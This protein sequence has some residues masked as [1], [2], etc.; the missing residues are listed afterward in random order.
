MGDGDE[1]TSKKTD[2]NLSDAIDPSSPYYLHPSDFPKKLHVN[3]VLTDGNYMDWAQEMSNFL[4][5][6]N[7]IDFVDGTI[8]KPKIGSTKY[9][10]WM[11]CDAMIK[12]WL[13]TAVEKIIRDS[14]KKS[15]PPV[16]MAAAFPPTT[17]VSELC[18]TSL[19]RSA[20]FRDA[21]AMA[22]HTQILATKLIP[23]L[24]TAYHMVA[25]DERHRKISN[26]NR[27]TSE[28]ATF[29][30]F[31]KREG[32]TRFFKEKSTNKKWP[33]KKGDK[34]KPMAACVDT[35]ASPILGISDE[36]YKLFVNFFSG[37]GSKNDVETKLEANLAGV[38]YEEL[39]WSGDVSFMENVFPFKN[40][41]EGNCYNDDG[42][43]KIQNETPHDI[44]D[45][46]KIL[47]EEESVQAQQE[48]G[49]DFGTINQQGGDDGVE[50]TFGSNLDLG[51]EGHDEPANIQN[52]PQRRSK[53]TKEGVD[54]H[55]TFAPVAKLVTVRTLLVIATK[56]N[57]IIH[58]LDVNN[59]FLH[60]DLDEEVYMKIP[61]GFSRDGET[62][63]GGVYVAILIY[64]DDVIII[65]NNTKKIQQTKKELDEE[66]SIKNLGPLKYFLRIEVAKK[67]DELVQGTKLD[68][69]EE[70]T[71]VD[72]TQ[73]RRLVGRLLYLQATRPDI[74]Y[75]KGTPG[76]GILL[77]REGPPVLTA[78]CD[79]DWLRCPFTR[80]SRMGYLLLL[81]GSPISW[82]TKKQSVVSRSLAEAEYRAMASTVSEI[83]WVRW[84]LKD[85]Q[86]RI[87]SVDMR[88]VR[89]VRIMLLE[90]WESV[91]LVD[92]T[93]VRLYCGGE[94]KK[95]GK[96]KG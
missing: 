43:T 14:V 57:W 44:L 53:R 94:M 17:L 46:Q 66:F 50:E 75:L 42:P 82:K 19:N 40:I 47:N 96:E 7:K 9:K 67:Y 31:Q 90:G 29:K 8:K 60:G 54:Y 18:G 73:Y 79:S 80:R 37:A 55:E 85:L 49:F 1:E 10:P 36:Q 35:G 12:G 38:T 20:P 39:D 95:E 22:A 13:T 16:K 76:Q 81:G 2:G 69:G 34:A 70:K 83:L 71:R 41:T 88:G 45:T 61:Q 28:S 25:E 30:A 59:A 72:A 24:R 93:L 77:K 65:G 62:R 84:L 63:V 74:T 26:E 23:T 3:E 4:Y 32:N 64:V 15:P 6:K 58:Q 92:F 51:P 91:Y 33:R 27:A 48:N 89:G 56:K 86:L 68:K 87:A 5:A 21:L 78:Y 11:R 52:E